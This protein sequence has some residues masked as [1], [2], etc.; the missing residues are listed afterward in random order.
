MTGTGG[1]DPLH[2]ETVAIDDEE[3]RVFRCSWGWC[4]KRGGVPYRART[5]LEAFE[6]AYGSRLV[7]PHLVHVIGLIERALDVQYAREQKTVSTAV[8]LTG[9]EVSLNPQ[10]AQA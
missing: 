1:C 8:D 9:P 6:E 5:L 3:L 7:A 4:L 2:H 10:P